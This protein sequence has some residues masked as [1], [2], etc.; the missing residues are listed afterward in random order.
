[1]DLQFAKGHG[2]KNDFVIFADEHDSLHLAPAQIARVCD[3]RSGI[4]A[5]GT[6]RAV[7]GRHIPQWDGDPDI[8]FMDYHNSDGSLAEM[9]GNGLRVFVKY[10]LAN[11]L[12]TGPVV[13]VGT[14]AG[15]RHGEM[16]DDGRIAVWMGKVVLADAP[17]ITVN[18]GERILAATKANVGNPH[19]VISLSGGGLAEID[20]R[21]PPTWSPREAFPDGVNIEFVERL[22]PGRVAMRVFERGSGETLACGTGIVAVAAFERRLSGLDQIIVECPGGTLEVRFAGDEGTLCGSAELVA[23]GVFDLREDL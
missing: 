23:R 5:D 4:G 21:E 6:L 7:R 8:W 1:M 18:A 22:T 3:R 14:R 11:G 2:A 13:Q 15:L 9:C 19:A 12:A 17:Q 10:L 20:L 16:L